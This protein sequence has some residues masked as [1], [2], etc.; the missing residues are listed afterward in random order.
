MEI[1][2]VKTKKEKKLFKKFRK[3]LYQNDPYYVS[4]TEFTLDMLLFK[5]TSFSKSISI[6]PVMGVKDNQILMTALLI[7][8]HKDD[9]L[10]ISFFEALPCIDEEVDF[11]V[12]YAKSFAKRLGLSRIII[13]LNG[14]LSYG[15]GLSVDMN[16]PN[17]FDSSYTKLY[18]LKY[19]EKYQRHE[20]VAFSNNP[21]AVF[22]TLTEK[23]SNVTIR[24]ID[25]NNFEEEMEKFRIICNETIGTTFL[26]S[27]TDSGHFYDLL[28]PMLFF[29]KPENILF[30]E[31]NG[32]IVG[33]IFWHPDYNEVLKK[34][35]QNGLLGIA[36][37]YLLFNKKIKRIKLN[38]IGVK[39]AYQG[40]VTIN[41]LRE[42]GKLVSNY[43]TVETN[44]VWTNN[45]KSMSI[46]QKLLKNIER[47][48]VV[49]EVNV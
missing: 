3:D 19:F 26:F 28:K 13:G 43:D 2:L 37:R 45:K 18:Y 41:L 48:F 23:R 42:V 9:Y 29:L 32:E 27:E 47:K 40:S 11:F 4:T 49:Y 35:K 33:F 38:S 8:N 44:F 21:A 15:V 14:H 1:R 25:F 46:N 30:A 7:H 17:T 24:K 5:E 20:L 39:K 10:Q 31:H 22:E 12:N 16:S 36:I 6:C 34:G